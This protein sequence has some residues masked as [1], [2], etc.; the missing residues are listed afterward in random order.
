MDNVKNALKLSTVVGENVKIYLSQM[1]KKIHLNCPPWLENVLKFTY[2][3]AKNAFKLS[4][5]VGENFEIYLSQMAK[6]AFKLS[7]MVGDIL[8]FTY[9]KWLKMHLNCPPWLDKI[10][11]SY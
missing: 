4:T 1:V 2:H 3:M 6:S 8:K 7:P 5:M 10:F 11:K 9:L